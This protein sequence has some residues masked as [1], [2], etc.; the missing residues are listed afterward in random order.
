MLGSWRN[1]GECFDGE[2]ALAKIS[3]DSQPTYVL[4][5]AGK[6]GAFIFLADRWRPKD[7]IDG[8]YVWLP[9]RW[10]DGKPR[11]AWSDRWD[12]SVFGRSEYV[13]ASAKPAAAG[14]SGR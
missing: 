12:M 2:P 9:V 6:P 13:D 14:P 3:Y 7:A 8:R 1:L 10:L 11:L 4:P 5:V